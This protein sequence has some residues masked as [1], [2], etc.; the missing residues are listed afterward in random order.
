M[1]EEILPYWGRHSINLPHQGRYSSPTVKELFP[2]WEELLSC[3]SPLYWVRNFSKWGVYCQGKDGLA[4]QELAL[5]LKASFLVDKSDQ[6][7]RWVR[8]LLRLIETFLRNLPTI[9]KFIGRLVK[10]AQETGDITEQ[11]SLQQALD[12]ISNPFYVAFGIGLCQTLDTFAES[13]LVSQKL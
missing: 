4:L 7:T 3:S 10:G 5:E 13:S 12:F 8:S 9:S 1:R 11:K 2:A 6:T